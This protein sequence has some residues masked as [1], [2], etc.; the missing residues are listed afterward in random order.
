[1]SLRFTVLASGSGGNA[2]LVEADGIG[3]LIDIGLGPRQLARRLAAVG[4][5]WQRI[6]AVVLSHMHGD[7]WQEPTL[8]H[9]LHLRIPL[10]CHDQ[11]IHTLPAWSK[12]FT[13]LHEAKLA[14]AYAPGLEL[15]LG[16][17]LSCRPFSVSHDG[18]ATCGFRFEGGRDIF[19][20]SCAL[21]YAADLGSW[22]AEHVEALSNVD[23]LAL[24]FNHDVEL[25]KSS[26]RSP[27][28]IARVLGPDGHLSN[29][30]AGAL[31]SQVIA[32]SAP[33]RPSR[34][35]QL[36]LSR[37]CNQPR[38][39]RSHARRILEDL[40]ARAPAIEIHTASQDRPSPTFHLGGVAHG[41][42]RTAR[43]VAGRKAAHSQA[44]LHPTLPGMDPEPSPEA[45][46]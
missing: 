37:E 30:Q 1:M 16:P 4:A 9:L 2:S 33:G 27:R 44:R 41:V 38:L 26:G 36:H 31:L 32:A 5:S 43:T 18:V 40:G 20:E 6:H 19:G 28:L 46:S 15:P 39:A 24:E 17:G 22:G 34:L 42:S 29:V 13:A 8:K 23:L 35:I 21:G 3:A 45:S 7:H 25:E 12:S 11:H 14:H 10:Y